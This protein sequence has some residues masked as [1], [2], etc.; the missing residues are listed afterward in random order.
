[1]LMILALVII[2]SSNL[3]VEAA[4]PT[5]V[6]S[7]INTETHWKVS[8]SP[9]IVLRSINVNAPLTID[10]G[11]A[12]KFKNDLSIFLRINNSLSAIGNANNKILF[13]STCD[14]SLVDTAEYCDNRWITKNGWQGIIII[15]N[16]N[17]IEFDNVIISY[18]SDGIRYKRTIIGPM[19]TEL[20]VRNSEIKNCYYS[21]LDLG[22]V[23]AKIEYNKIHDNYYGIFTGGNFKSNSIIRNNAI[24]RNR[25]AGFYDQDLF[26]NI[27]V[28]YNWWGDIS[29]PKYHHPYYSELSNWD[30]KGNQIVG[31]NVEFRPWLLSENDVINPGCQENC[32]SNVMFLPG[33]KAS[34]LYKKGSLGMEDKLWPPNFF[35]NDLE[36]LALDENGKSINN[37]YTRDAIDEVAIPE[38]GGNIYKSFLNKLEDLKTSGIINDY[39]SFA[40]DWRQNVEDIAQ[41]GTPYENQTKS[42]VENLVALAEKSKSEK[43]TIVAH[44]N[45]GLLAKAI[46]IELEKRGLVN[47]VD[48]IIMVGTPQMGTP[49]AT[50]S[51]L[52]GYDEAAL[53]GTLISRE[54]SRDMAENMPGA[55][56]LLPSNEYFS[57]SEN[58]FISFS[59]QNTRYK[60]FADEYGEHISNQDEFFKFLTGSGGREK[61][62]S[63]E[64]EK[65]NVLNEKLLAKANEMH[66]H[67]D[68][69]SPPEGVKVIQI[70]GWGLDTVSGVKYTEKEKVECFPV[71]SK[72][73]VCM[74]M[75]EYEPIYEPEFTVDGD[76]VVVTPSAL[77][78]SESDRIE[79]YWVDLWTYDDLL[80][81]GRKHKDILEVS[82]VL[83]FVENII[84]DLNEPLP[85]NIKTERPNPAE[86]DNQK[87]RLRMSLYSPLNIHL[88][89]EYGNHTGPKMISIDG[90]EKIVFEEGIP[91][92]YYYQFGDRKYVGFNESE[93]IKVKMEGY[94]IGSYTLKM[95]EIEINENGE[96][97]ISKTEFKNLPTADQTKVTFEIPS[98]GLSEMTELQAD[99]D[100]DGKLDYRIDKSDNGA[101]ELPITIEMITEKV[102]ILTTLGFIQNEETKDF[103]NVKLKELLH[104]GEMIE[105]MEKKKN[106]NP[107]KNQIKLFNKK[108][109]DL[110]DFINEKLDDGMNQIAQDILIKD[111]ES[112]KI[113]Q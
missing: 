69:W 98:N 12:V 87:P 83:E 21:G 81:L 17:K 60:D 15:N 96:S 2:F 92:S 45:G 6:D 9:Y 71:D 86:Y 44:S 41:N 50:L 80:T 109:D 4:G 59:S 70:A 82:P 14:N 107:R 19:P 25:V 30:G 39:S 3:K 78:M 65:E 113:K 73:P 67:L 56:G 48:K 110:I 31:R 46:M 93:N 58:P 8:G 85:Q 94:D 11:V 43:V 7:D 103:L 29:G 74:G 13:T 101:A 27:D 16:I 52:Y 63:S 34:R 90:K 40:Y 33:I 18:A 111:L 20:K 28:R 79:R 76:K 61:P 49:L 99:V 55:Y 53:F 105:K 72:I 54:D 47:K 89:D 66:E 42:A 104:V 24:Y 37:V 68:N 102:N 36:D 97:I 100:N 64:L 84:K 51:L 5:F 35:G 88:Y 1:M 91:N 62:D 108:I 10:P 22:V 95:E 57:R 75:G 38:I 23:S 77:M 26:T 112:V 106:D 32:F